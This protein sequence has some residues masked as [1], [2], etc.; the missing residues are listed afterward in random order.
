M[1]TRLTF[2]YDEVGDILFIRSLPPYAEQE[3]EQLEY[4]ILARRNPRTRA[5]EAVEVMFFTRWLLRQGE[6]RA[7]NLA[8]LFSRPAAAA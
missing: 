8:E 4:N 2:E 7:M 3:T 5:I 1:E 6:P